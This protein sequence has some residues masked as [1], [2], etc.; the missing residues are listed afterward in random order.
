MDD[1]KDMSDYALR[2]EIYGLLGRLGA[3]DPPEDCGGCGCSVLEHVTVRHNGAN[4]ETPCRNCP[5][6][7]YGGI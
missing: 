4:W 1:F 5:C 2:R 3:F 6:T 7:Q